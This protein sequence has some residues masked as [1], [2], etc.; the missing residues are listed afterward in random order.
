M[1]KPIGIGLLDY[2]GLVPAR[3]LGSIMC[4]Y[5]RYGASVRFRDSAENMECSRFEKGIGTGG[6]LMYTV[7]ET[8]YN[9][10]L[11]CLFPSSVLLPFLA[12]GHDRTYLC[13]L[14]PMT[15]AL[16]AQSNTKRLNEIIPTLW[17]HQENLAS[18]SG[19][20]ERGGGAHARSG[21]S[22]G[23]E[24]H[25]AVPPVTNMMQNEKPFPPE[26]SDLELGAK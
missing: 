17:V 26:R 14:L 1:P 6:G 4:S 5:M 11:G 3:R 24:H 18:R 16:E 13:M 15:P 7:H 22:A 8:A 12:S 21:A 20:L 23:P 25:H 9:S 10:C 2:K 19:E